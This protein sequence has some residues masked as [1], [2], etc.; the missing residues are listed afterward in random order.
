[1]EARLPSQER[2][3]VR[4]PRHA[5]PHRLAVGS[6]VLS[7][8]AGVQLPVR[9]HRKEGAT[10]GAGIPL[11][12]S[13]NGTQWP[14]ADRGPIVY[15]LGSR[16]FKPG[17]RVRIP[18]GLRRGS[19]GRYG[20]GLITRKS[21]VQIPPPQPFLRSLSRQSC[22]LLIRQCWFEPSRRSSRGRSS[23][24][25][26]AGSSPRR[27]PVQVRS[28]PPCP[29]SSAE[30]RCLDKAEAGGSAPPAGTRSRWSSG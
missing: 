14:T 4:I 24:G 28:V 20:A 8:Q 26:S 5:R 2:I 13:A 15:G 25:Q 19:Q 18:V 17:N 21:W 30:E 11:G 29:L 9:L 16:P 23:D 6:L 22:G 1:M 3:G 12:G 7:E 27:S 10:A